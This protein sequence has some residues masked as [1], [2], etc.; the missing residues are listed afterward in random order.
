MTVFP[1]DVSPHVHYSTT[2]SCV[3]RRGGKCTCCTDV[4]RV[5][6]SYLHSKHQ[7]KIDILNNHPDNFSVIVLRLDQKITGKFSQESQLQHK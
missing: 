5:H 7:E 1:G 3:P 2:T 6:Q 4:R